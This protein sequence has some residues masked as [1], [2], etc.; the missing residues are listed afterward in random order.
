V[1]DTQISVMLRPLNTSDL[2]PVHDLLSDWNV[3]RYR[4]TVPKPM[5]PPLNEQC[6]EDQIYLRRLGARLP[7]DRSYAIPPDGSLPSEQEKVVAAK[8]A[9][10]GLKKPLQSRLQGIAGAYAPEIDGS[11]MRAAC[12][13]QPY[14]GADHEAAS[15]FAAPVAPGPARFGDGAE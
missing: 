12:G 6:P 14:S 3:V 1:P 2:E 9:V 8:R 4:R 10:V 15:A 5:N 11:A 13:E 7:H